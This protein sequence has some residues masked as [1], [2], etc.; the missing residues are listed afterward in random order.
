M[1]RQGQ[2]DHRRHSAIKAYVLSAD[3][4]TRAARIVPLLLV[5]FSLSACESATP[6]GG[7]TADRGDSIA[8]RAQR[9]PDLGIELDMLPTLDPVGVQLAEVAFVEARLSPQRRVFRRD[10]TSTLEIS[11]SDRYGQSI[12]LPLDALRIQPRPESCAE[13]D[14]EGQVSFLLEGPGA[15]RIC[16]SPDV[17]GRVSFLIDDAPPSI[18]LDSPVEGLIIEGE[19]TPIVVA[20]QVSGQQRLLVNEM[21]VP[22]D[23]EGRFSVEVLPRFGYNQIEVIADDGVHIPP[24]RLLRAPLY[25]PRLL[26][27]EAGRPIELSPVLRLSMG[28]LA[29]TGE[30]AAPPAE[31]EE[32]LSAASL[33]AALEQLLTLIDPLTFLDDPQLASGDDLSLRVEGIELIDP[34][35]DITPSTE[36][37]DLFLWIPQIQ[38]QSTGLLRFE[39]LELDLTGLIEVE[40]AAFAL[41]TPRQAGR[42][43][44]LELVDLGVSLGR[45]R[46]QL[47][48]PEAQA[49][50]DTLGSLLQGLLREAAESLAERLL[51]EALG[52]QLQAGFSLTLDALE[53]ITFEEELGPELGAID[54][55]L[56]LEISP[57]TL[58][59]RGLTLELAGELDAPADPTLQDLPIPAHL[60]A[61]SAPPGDESIR[62]AVPL[63]VINGLLY[64]CWRQGLF[65]RD[66]SELIPE[67]FRALIST[68]QLSSPR[69]PLLTPPPS[70][71]R[72]FS[73]QLDQLTLAIEAPDGR[74]DLYQVSLSVP[75]TFLLDRTQAKLDF[76]TPPSLQVKLAEEGGPRPVLPPDLLN[77]SLQA[78][79]WPQ[80]TPILEEGLQLSV[81]QVSLLLDALGLP[82]YTL[83]L[84]PQFQPTIRFESGW[85][86]FAATPLLRF[87]RRE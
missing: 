61:P 58:D 5:A 83:D 15:L 10:E 53:S 81:P 56:G 12:D 44:N 27:T 84:V 60:R 85:I 74:R 32:A 33:S 62:L 39:G 37:L 82:A 70:P 68:L 13:V 45:L 49:I 11:L 28:S 20:G 23:E 63:E 54:L 42:E 43:L 25:A 40:L 77:D 80:L 18:R 59:E 26:S 50:L 38:F 76:P 46:G 17:C 64:Q 73:L 72:P 48:D 29:F 52:E 24:P 2:T 66:L 35:I 8:D 16:A 6:T 9:V 30:R 3:R 22:V 34:I 69:P 1:K 4:P 47:P 71:G 36:G 57:P 31:G 51:T 67:G 19:P 55:T 65:E 78:L 86:L 7:V 41:L 21:L 79:F 87:L 14:E 75:A